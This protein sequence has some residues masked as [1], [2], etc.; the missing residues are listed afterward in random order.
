[1]GCVVYPRVCGGTPR[2][3]ACGC[4]VRGLSPRVRGNRRVGG[5][6]AG[7]AGSIPA[8]AGE[9]M[10]A[11]VARAA[12]RVYPRVCG[13]TIRTAATTART[14]GLSP[15]V[16]GNPQD[17]GGQGGRGGSIPACA[18]EPRASATRRRAAGVYPRVCGGTRLPEFAM[19]RQRGLSPRV[20]GNRGCRGWR[21]CGRRSIPACAGEPRITARSYCS[22]TVYPRVCGGTKR[23]STRDPLPA[24]LS[25]RVRGNRRNE[26]RRQSNGR[27]IPACAGEP[28]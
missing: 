1:M 11:V 26:G 8:C 15:R 24:G 18:G 4:L 10:P 22:S 23:K 9:P 25:P 2:P 5:S 6:A 27:S 17:G 14:A 13:G 19:R 3:R 7:K 20:R 12:T 16:R 28:W 21:A